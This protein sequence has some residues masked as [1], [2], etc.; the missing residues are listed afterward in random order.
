VIVFDQPYNRELAGPRA[1]TWDEV[2]EIVLALAAQR[3]AVQPQFP[4][5]DAGADRLTR[6]RRTSDDR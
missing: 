3:G 5:F 1:T 4:G 6:R 2:E